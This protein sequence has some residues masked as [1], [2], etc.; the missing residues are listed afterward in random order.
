MG[1]F[2]RHLKQ[3]NPHVSQSTDRST[4]PAP[5]WGYTQHSTA[6]PPTAETRAF[7]RTTQTWRRSLLCSCRQWEQKAPELGALHTHPFHSLYKVPQYLVHKASSCQCQQSSAVVGNSTARPRRWA[8]KH[9]PMCLQSMDPAIKGEGWEEHFPPLPD[10]QQAS[11][12]E[13]LK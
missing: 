13:W 11:K 10:S 7:L 1:S 5:V 2:K 3:E 4:R 9:P 6:L 12:W 8:L